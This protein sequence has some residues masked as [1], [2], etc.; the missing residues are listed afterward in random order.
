MRCQFL[1][2]SLDQVINMFK[3]MREQVLPNRRA[4]TRE[5]KK[6]NFSR[7]LVRTVMYTFLQADRLTLKVIQFPRISTEAYNRKPYFEHSP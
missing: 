1:T 4:M 6:V 3:L 5:I 7:I 2:N